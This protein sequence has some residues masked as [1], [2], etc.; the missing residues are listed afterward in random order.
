ML[1]KVIFA[2]SKVDNIKNGI[3]NNVYAY[4]NIYTSVDK[5]L[6]LLVELNTYIHTVLHKLF[7]NYRVY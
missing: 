2:F 3:E 7:F 4:I 5:D 1:L 6:K